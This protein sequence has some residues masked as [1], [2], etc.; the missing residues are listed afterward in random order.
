MMTSLVVIVQVLVLISVVTARHVRESRQM[1]FGRPIDLL[2]ATLLKQ[3]SVGKNSPDS[4]AV[5][6][7]R[8]YV[9]FNN[10]NQ[11]SVFDAVTFASLP[12]ISLSFSDD[13]VKWGRELFTC[14]QT[15]ALYI[16]EKNPEK[17]LRI[18]KIEDAT[19]SL[20]LEEPLEEAGITDVTVSGTGCDIVVSRVYQN[21]VGTITLY[22][23]NATLD[24]RVKFEPSYIFPIQAFETKWKTFLVT[25]GPTSRHV[26]VELNH[27]G[28][29]LRSLPRDEEQRNLA[30]LSYAALSTIDSTGN[31]FV[32]DGKAKFVAI[33]D[34]DLSHSRLLFKLADDAAIDCIYYDSQN[35]RLL[36]CNSGAVAGVDIYNIKFPIQD[37]FELVDF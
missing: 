12:P 18:W 14:P 20:W 9:A 4:V 21:D 8:I 36:L 10:E 33:V 29:V 37:A 26:T 23:A 17:G 13:K 16:A 15:G 32:V 11:V 27:M 1:M 6:N 30:S 22:F 31:L 2:E 35:G 28:E 25:V 34:E 24:R 7:G 19:Q 5:I 3:L